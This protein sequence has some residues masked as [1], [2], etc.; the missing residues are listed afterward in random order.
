VAAAQASE[1]AKAILCQFRPSSTAR[2]TSEGD[3]FL[4]AGRTVTLRCIETCVEDRV[5]TQRHVA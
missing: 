5:A 1:P 2:A 3:G 4:F